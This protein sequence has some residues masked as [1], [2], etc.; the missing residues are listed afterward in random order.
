MI[1]MDFNTMTAL[2]R[3][4]IMNRTSFL[5]YED[6]M[7]LKLDLS[8]LEEISQVERI[9][10]YFVML[11]SNMPK[12]SIVGLVDLTGL[13]V[14]NEVLEVLINLAELSNPHFRATAVLTS[15][16]ET[17]DLAKAVINHFGK[18]NMPIFQEE[19]AAKKWL[20]SQ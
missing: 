16:P 7:I 18:I 2:K 5:R 6:K 4:Q 19:E 1:R 3:A 15:S 9:V 13:K 20:F 8:H 10:D 17:T 11:I 12:K 14:A